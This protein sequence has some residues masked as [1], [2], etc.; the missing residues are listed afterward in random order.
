MRIASIVAILL[1]CISPTITAYEI[2]RELLPRMDDTWYGLLDDLS[3]KEDSIITSW[4]DYGHWFHAIAQQRVTFDGGDQGKR[5][6]WVGKSLLTNN[7][8][9]SKDILRML[10]CGQ[11]KGYELLAN[12]IGDYQ[13]VKEL[14]ALIAMNKSTAQGRLEELN[15]A[16]NL[17]EQILEKTH[18]ETTLQQY[19]IATEEMVSLSTIWGHF[20]AWNFT[21]AQLYAQTKSGEVSQLDLDQETYAQLTTQAKNLR[22]SKEAE[23][24][25]APWPRYIFQDS[26]RCDET[27]T[28]IRCPLHILV[29]S[30]EDKRMYIETAVINRTAPE[31]SHLEIITYQGSEQILLTRDP[32]GSL[33]LWENA[34]WN[35]YIFEENVFP[36]NLAIG[37]TEDNETHLVIGEHGL[38]AST[39]SKLYFFAGKG[40]EGFEKVRE[41]STFDGKRILTYR[42]NFE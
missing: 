3:Q 26:I 9:E 30:K 41:D 4:W 42:V 35:D 16:E 5:I 6:Y 15:I 32:M 21:R 12:E 31:N 20:G 29:D 25:I 1:L 19:V 13:A 38:S 22:S 10:N 37:L 11:E 28:S 27:S 23:T 33:T 2:N 8:Q 40:M 39:F 18:C 36:Y 24:W 34:S 17:Q 14:E 7:P